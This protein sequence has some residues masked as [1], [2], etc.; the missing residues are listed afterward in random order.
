MGKWG[1]EYIHC[2]YGDPLHLKRIHTIETSGKGNRAGEG[3]SHE[4]QESNDGKLH[5]CGIDFSKSD[6]EMESRSSG[7]KC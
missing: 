6:G 1:D 2:G 5:D 7:D 3:N 4:G